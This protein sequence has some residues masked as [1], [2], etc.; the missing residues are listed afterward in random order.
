MKNNQYQCF[1][2]SCL[3]RIDKQNNIPRYPQIYYV[4]VDLFRLI[5]YFLLPY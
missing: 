5:K 3:H 1:S 4:Q 2:A